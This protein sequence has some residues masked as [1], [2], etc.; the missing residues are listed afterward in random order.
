MNIYVYD[1]VQVLQH[2]KPRMP[3]QA[4]ANQLNLDSIPQDISELSTIERRL[5]SYRFTIYHFNCYEKS[6]EDTT[7][8]NGPPV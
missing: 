1:V 3:D 4:C 2:S 6:M 8:F 7:K 5:I